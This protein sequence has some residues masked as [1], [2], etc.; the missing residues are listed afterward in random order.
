MFT[1]DIVSCANALINVV[2]NE[3][4]SKIK[5]IQKSKKYNNNNKKKY[6]TL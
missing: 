5:Q 3:E 2:V 4:N 6:F 1:G